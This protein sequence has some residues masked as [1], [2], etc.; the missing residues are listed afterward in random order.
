M[1]KV[2]RVYHY[3]IKSWVDENNEK[4]CESDIT[5]DESIAKSIDKD[6][7]LASIDQINELIGLGYE[8]IKVIEVVEGVFG[9]VEMISYITVLGDE[10]VFQGYIYFQP[11]SEQEIRDLSDMISRSMK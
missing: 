9:W 2:Q 5:T 11:N 7:K 1:L 3:V 8:P 10:E 6:Y 4:W